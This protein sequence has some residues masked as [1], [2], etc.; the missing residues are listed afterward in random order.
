MLRERE[1]REGYLAAGRH[2]GIKQGRGEA[3][4]QHQK[5]V[6]Q[7]R[8]Q[9]TDLMGLVKT[10]QGAGE[11]LEARVQAGGKQLSARDRAIR[12]LQ[13]GQGQQGM[14]LQDASARLRAGGRQLSQ[15]DARIRGLQREGTAAKQ[16]IGALMQEGRALE[17]SSKKKIRGLQEGMG[18]EGLARQQA[19]T[20][21]GQLLQE[22]RSLES[23]SKRQIRE[24]QEGMGRE[25]LAKQ[26]AQGEVR[27]LQGELRQ[28]QQTGSA[29]RVRLE[30]ELAAAQ[31]SLAEARRRPATKAA[32]AP[33]ITVSA[34]GG[35]G[36]SSS[37]SGGAASGGGGQQ[38]AAR[39]P[40]LSK[41]VEAVKKVAEAAQA[42]KKA[43]AAK[44]SAKGITQARRRYTDKRKTT[45]AALRALK[46]KRIRE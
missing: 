44:G 32:G 34:P 27:R 12:Q 43:P 40:D 2:L 20:R 25:G 11:T 16:R 29:D 18:R 31:A 6:D 30:R 10:M 13:V 21:V 7:L 36:A 41:V 4:R 17:A 14:A 23:T 24:L 37:S 35:G 5:A 8:R 39:A 38:A 1:D 3:R 42:A 28:A 46:S 45:L 26:Q 19:Q 33:I 22:G 15:R 9:N